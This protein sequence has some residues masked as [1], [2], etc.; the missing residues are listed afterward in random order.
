MKDLFESEHPEFGAWPL[1]RTDVKEDAIRWAS[2]KIKSGGTDI[3]ATPAEDEVETQIM[4]LARLELSHAAAEHHA[5]EGEIATL[6]DRVSIASDAPEQALTKLLNRIVTTHRQH[7]SSAVDLDATRLAADVAVSAEATRHGLTRP[8]Q[9]DT[10]G[11]IVGYAIGFI[12]V[13]AL[14]TAM[15][16]L[17]QT[18]SSGA[19][20]AVGLALVAATSNIGLG[21][22]LMGSVM[23][24]RTQKRNSSGAM[25]WLFRGLCVLSVAWIII[26]NFLLGHFRAS[27]GNFAEALVSF[28]RNPL[29]VGDMTGLLLAGFG[30][31]LASAWCVKFYGSQDPHLRYGELGQRLTQAQDAVRHNQADYAEDVRSFADDALEELDDIADDAATGAGLATDM[32]AASKTFAQQFEEQQRSLAA[33]TN[34]MVMYRRS[35]LREMLNPHGL[36]PNYLNQ[37]IDVSDLT[38]PMTDVDAIA[39]QTAELVSNAKAVV[40]A[41]RAA[42]EKVEKIVS[43]ALSMPFGTTI[44]PPLQIGGQNV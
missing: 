22:Y 21:G 40:D 35:V 24:P 3:P 7:S 32:L 12:G 6:R 4:D 18:G 43:Q 25:A 34:E 1:D 19:A 36:S 30:L 2:V 17:G 38:R 42:R 37:P 9:P 23:L 8:P 16:F 20:A 29:N 5:Q 15:T 28:L 33:S 10:S 27:S 26:T 11:T 14:V 13:E 41:A 39:E 31:V 44:H